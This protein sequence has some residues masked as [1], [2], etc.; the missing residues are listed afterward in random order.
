MPKYHDIVRNSAI[1]RAA[2][3][4]K[5]MLEIEDVVEDLVEELGIDFDM[6][7]VEGL[8][9]VHVDSVEVYINTEARCYREL[10]VEDVIVEVVCRRVKPNIAEVYKY[11]AVNMV[12]IAVD[13][14]KP[15]ITRYEEYMAI[16][17]EDG[18]AVILQGSPDKV[19]VPMVPGTLLI[20]HTHPRSFKAVLS[21]EDIRSLIELLSRRGFGFCVLSQNSC[22]AIYRRG[23]FIL[24]DYFKL[25]NTMKEYGYLDSEILRS[26]NLSSIDY[27]EIAI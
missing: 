2:F 1:E 26:L 12:S 5:L 9:N 15:F 22:L 18:Y 10:E 20:C 24:D 23:F 7:R 19:V 11:L 21:K 13:L 8:E 6:Y 3:L 4:S 25:F 17:I 14:L 16:L 27:L